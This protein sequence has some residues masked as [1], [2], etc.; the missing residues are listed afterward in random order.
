MNRYQNEIETII[1]K[2]GEMKQVIVYGAQKRAELILPFC[3]TFVDPAKIQ[4]VVSNLSRGGVFLYHYEV[5]AVDDVRIDEATVVLVAAGEQYF[6]EIG[7]LAKVRMAGAVFYLKQELVMEAK[8][9]AINYRFQKAGIDLRLFDGIFERD[10]V[11][12][13][14][15][16]LLGM[17]SIYEKAY[18]L[19]LEDSAYYVIRNMGT[20]YSFRSRGEYHEW[21]CE[22]I[23]ENQS[24]SGIN[25]EFGVA[26]GAS[27]VKFAERTQNQFYGFDSFEGLP[28]DWIV[29]F[30]KGEFKTNK[31]LEM[32]DHVE[33]VKGYY[34]DSLPTFMQR[35]DVVGRRAD[36]IHI[37]CD[38]YTSTKTVF[39]YIAPLIQ[40]G[41]I[42]AFDEYFNYPGWQLGEYKA[43]QEYVEQNRVKYEYIAYNDRGSQVCVRII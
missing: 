34:N 38:L 31:L 7:S 4:I 18:E 10:L 8:R 36:F 32:P 24:E 1:R 5:K 22:T 19:A 37:D 16:Q 40:E 20:A 29:G 9:Y 42:I 39:E 15:E 23:E 28:E 12:R 43:F 2:M 11:D 35:E 27:I 21:L 17:N 26:Y 30:C 33:L 25:L 13:K 6:D 41:T 3:E 14:P